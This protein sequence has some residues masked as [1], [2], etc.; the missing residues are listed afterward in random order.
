MST[1]ITI[2]PTIEP[3]VPLENNSAQLLPSPNLTSTT[4][5][6]IESFNKL[7]NCFKQTVTSFSIKYSTII[8]RIDNLKLRITELEDHLTENTAPD[9]IVKQFKN[10]LKQENELLIKQAIIKMK[11]NQL[12][13]LRITQ[14]NELIVEFNN[15][16]VVFQP[17]INLVIQTITDSTIPTSPIF[18]N[19]YLD[20]FISLK[21]IEFRVKQ[22]LDSEKKAK[23]QLLFNEKTAADAV[24]VVI[25]HKELKTLTRKLKKLETKLKTPPKQNTTKKQASK[26][27]NNSTSTTKKEFR[28]E[29]A[30][31]NEIKAKKKLLFNERT[32]TDAIP[33]VITHKELKTLTSKLQGLVLNC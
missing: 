12:L 18:W 2:D 29:Q 21:L 24:P 5:I 3:S 23:K 27:N 31:D 14:T 17:H 33:V 16:H 7:P 11:M 25:T 19:P 9:F 6:V 15:R 20:Y 28:R 1:P 8:C 26:R 4:S 22:A 30:L 10:I 32:T 13:T